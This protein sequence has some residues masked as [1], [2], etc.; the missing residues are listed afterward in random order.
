MLSSPFSAENVLLE[1]CWWVPIAFGGA[2]V[3]L[4]AAHPQLDV[5]WGGGRKEPAGWAVVLLSIGCFVG[6]YELSGA[7]AEGAALR[8]VHDW[9]S[10]DL[11]LMLCAIAIFLA[12]ERTA[13]G[14]FMMVLLAVIG[15]VVEILLINGLHLYEYS[16]PDIWGIPSWIAWVYAAGGPPNGALGRQVLY[17]LMERD[18]RDKQES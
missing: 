10:L 4:G 17:E 1:T 12:F 16:H 7:L 5:W 14:L 8:G 11:P 15:P 6:C 2:G 13:G 9:A 18:S 3:V